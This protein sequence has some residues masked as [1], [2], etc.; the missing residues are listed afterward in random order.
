MNE[1]FQLEQ[2]RRML[3]DPGLK[4]GLYL[5]D[6]AL[7]DSDIEIVIQG[8]GDCY[9][10]KEQLMTS[11]SDSPFEMFVTGLSCYCKTL[12]STKNGRV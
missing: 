3:M 7:N 10:V 2:L 1:D 9:F 12:V 4:S 5:I 11:L 8:I 6:T